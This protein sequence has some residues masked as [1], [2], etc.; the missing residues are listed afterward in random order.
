MNRP[1]FISFEGADGSGKTTQIKLLEEKLKTKQIQTIVT[2]EPGGTL[3]SEKIRSILLDNS[4]GKLDYRAEALLYAA[5]RAEHVSKVIKPALDAG[6]VVITD[7]YIDSSLA[8]QGIVRGLGVEEVFDI[9]SFA[10]GGLMP[11][12]TILLHLTSVQERLRGRDEPPDRIE[13]EGNSFQE[14][15]IG[16]YLELSRLYSDRFVVIDAEREAGSISE[17]IIQNV[18]KELSK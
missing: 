3:V 5:D 11:D 13:S 18:M 15:V 8:Y 16:A 4:S 7:R 12:I 2:R 17:I 14:K 9:N 10:T 6:T 1:L